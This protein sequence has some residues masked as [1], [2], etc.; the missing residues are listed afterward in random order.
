LI[1][2]V[3]TTEKTGNIDMKVNNIYGKN[4]NGLKAAWGDRLQV[5]IQSPEEL[6]INYPQRTFNAWGDIPKVVIQ[7][8][9]ELE[10]NYFQ[11]TFNSPKE[12]V[13]QSRLSNEQNPEEPKKEEENNKPEKLP[14]LTR[15]AEAEYVKKNVGN[16]KQKLPTETKTSS[17]EKGNK[18]AAW[19][20]SNITNPDH[21]YVINGEYKHDNYRSR[22][23]GVRPCYAQRIANNEVA[24]GGN[25][26]GL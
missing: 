6:E 15:Y 23:S 11:R 3:F 2:A 19:D 24:K 17:T 25:G 7:S 21:K 13:S 20:S 14:P 5:V 8:P 12:R 4:Q 22:S 18:N 9:E 16:N 10:I 26:S 1:E